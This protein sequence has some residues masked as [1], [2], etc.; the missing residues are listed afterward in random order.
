MTLFTRP[1]LIIDTETTGFLDDSET[2]PWEIGAVLLSPSGEELSTFSAVGCPAVLD[3]RM[4]PALRIGGVTMEYLRDHLPMTE[5]V[6]EFLEWLHERDDA[7]SFGWSAFN[8]A[9]DRPMLKRI[10]IESASW[11]PCIMERAKPI[12]GK[13][14]ALP[15]FN[16]YNDWKMPKLSEAA[17]FFNVPQQEPAHRALA[18]ARTAG[19]I[20]IELQRR[21][22]ERRAVAP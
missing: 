2:Q 5:I 9:F 22:L 4:L 12:M 21:A 17:A 16:K 11:S 14:G 13:A 15:W 3:D 8:I 19:L 1:L 10:G 18:D 20:A 6:A 7:D